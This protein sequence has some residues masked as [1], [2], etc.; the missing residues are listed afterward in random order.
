MAPSARAAERDTLNVARIAGY[1]GYFDGS[2]KV[3]FGSRQRYDGVE[4]A[5]DL[6]VVRIPKEGVG[7]ETRLQTGG[8]VS[9][10]NDRVGRFGTFDVALDAAIYRGATFGLCAGAGL[11]VEFGRHEFTERVRFYPLAAVR[12]RLFPN[13]ALSFHLNLHA[14]PITTGEKDRELRTELAVGYHALFVGFRASVI[15]FTAGDPRRTYGELGLG[16][17]AGA[18]F[19]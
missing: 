6:D 8:G 14:I 17:I 13:D 10:G 3:G 2:K 7:V 11:G 5:L 16:V 15:S 4:F 1:A 18:A 9:T 19:Y 12:A